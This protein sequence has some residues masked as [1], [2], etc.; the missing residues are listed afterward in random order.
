MWRPANI[1][2]SFLVFEDVRLALQ[3]EPEGL[4]A[5]GE[6]ADND[7]DLQGKGALAG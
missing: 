1:V 2:R 4:Y 5:G 3:G 7:P 6:Q